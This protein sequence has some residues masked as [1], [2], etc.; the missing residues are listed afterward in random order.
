MATL[1]PSRE[2]TCTTPADDNEID[3]LNDWYFSSRRRN[4]LHCLSVEGSHAA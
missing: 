2:D 4:A 3:L 1:K